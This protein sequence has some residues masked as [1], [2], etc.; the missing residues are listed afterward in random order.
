MTSPVGGTRARPHGWLGNASVGTL[1]GIEWRRVVDLPFSA[2]E[3]MMNPLNEG[4][5]VRIARCLELD[6]CCHHVVDGLVEFWYSGIPCQPWAHDVVSCLLCHC[7][8]AQVVLCNRD[9]QELPATLG[10]DMVNL[11][12]KFAQQ[13]GVAKPVPPPRPP[14]PSVPMG[15][16]QPRP[17]PPRPPGIPPGM[18]PGSSNAS[19]AGA[20]GMASMPMAD[21]NAIVFNEM[22]VPVGNLGS[23][24]MGMGMGMNGRLAP[25]G[26][27]APLGGM[28]MNGSMGMA[29][30]MPGIMGQGMLVGSLQSTS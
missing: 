25:G 21:P 1:F 29:N 7:L 23:L 22:G 27:M 12:E 15:G 6:P 3:N 13:M 11:F 24:G 2:T 9:G 16:G 30:G 10:R 19:G 28:G 18:R 17:P 8:E 14:A 26:G 4:K 20:L 5:P